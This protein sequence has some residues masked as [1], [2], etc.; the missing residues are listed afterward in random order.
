MKI[1]LINHF[2]L[3]GSGSGIY[4]LNLYNKLNMMGNDVKVIFPDHNL[5][6]FNKDFI[7]I[8]TKGG[9]AKDYQLP[10]NF[11]C[12]TTHPVSNNTFYNLKDQEIE[13]YIDVFK[14]TLE[15]V[16]DEFNPDIIHCQHMWIMPYI[17]SKFNIPYG[18]TVHGTDIK[19][20]KK[21]TRYHKY[22][23]EAARNASFIITISRQ[24]DQETSQLFGIKDDRR[25]LV[26]NGFD[27]SIFY[28]KDFDEDFL[29]KK[30]NI[31]DDINYIVSFVG[32][33]T[34]FKG[35]DILLDAAQI[36]E[37]QIGNVATIIVGDGS[38]RDKLE[39]QARENGLKNVVFMGHRSQTEVANIYNMADVSVI[40]SRIEPFGLVAL[41]AMACGTPVVATNAGGLPDFVNSHVGSLVKQDHPK[42]LAQAIMEELSG[43]SKATKGRHAYFYAHANFTWDSVAQKVENIYNNVLRDKNSRRAFNENDYGYS[44]VLEQTIPPRLERR[45]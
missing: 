36:Y 12:F 15:K 13:Q 28:T 44:H 29:K 1:V 8:I 26:H 3:Q 27:E 35:V 32:K 2:P 20:Y 45:G 14:G 37:K 41:E 10:F 40:P 5:H 23:K 21:D 38:D 19:G 9:K 22:V 16:I 33:L 7:P 24:V 18:V 17:A 42:E 4:T 34:H 11:P 30:Y 31:S 25:F 39:R 6:P 43:H